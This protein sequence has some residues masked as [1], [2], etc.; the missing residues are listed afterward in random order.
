[1]EQPV[2]AATLTRYSVQKSSIDGTGFSPIYVFTATDLN[3]GVNSDGAFPR[4]GLVLD[5]STLYGN[6][7]KRG[8][9]ANGT[10]FK[11]NTN[12]NWFCH[13]CMRSS[14][15]TPTLARIATELL[16]RQI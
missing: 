9:G 8:A 13:V 14:L 4:G 7:L 6:R 15:R 2:R 16:R 11:V 12:G 1:M 10:V 3:S 5:G